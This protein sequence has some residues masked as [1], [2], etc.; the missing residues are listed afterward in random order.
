LEVCFL[1]VGQGTSNVVLLGDRRAVVVDCGGAQAETVLALLG[2]FQIDTL[3]R[4]IASHSHDDHSRGAA[5]VLTAFQGRID[6]VW[7]LDQR[8]ADHQAMID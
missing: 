6:E 3:T 1:D 4:L 5:A 7:M 2:R 8:F